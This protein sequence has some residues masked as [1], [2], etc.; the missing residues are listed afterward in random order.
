[1]IASL[2]ML[3]LILS[4]PVKANDQQPYFT[5]SILTVYNATTI[6]TANYQYVII[7]NTHQLN[8]TL[9][10]KLSE[11]EEANIVVDPILEINNKTLLANIFIN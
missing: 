9:G 3:T 7:H 5:D 10:E 6:E 4:L 11:F 2:V 8:I 1:M